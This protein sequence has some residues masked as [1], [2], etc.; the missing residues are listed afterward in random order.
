MSQR[1]QTFGAEGAVGEGNGVRMLVGVR[2]RG[3]H[4]QLFHCC[5]LSLSPH[6]GGLARG[7]TGERVYL[8]LV[9][10]SENVLCGAATG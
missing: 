6:L 3:P 9:R 5:T 7:S 10:R 2:R 8:E 1:Q 4:S